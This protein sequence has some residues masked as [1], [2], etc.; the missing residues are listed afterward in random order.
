MTNLFADLPH[1]LPD[2]LFTTPL[3][4]TNVRIERIVSQGHSSPAGFWYEEDQHEMVIVLKGGGLARFRGSN[5]RDKARRLP[6]HPGPREA[7]C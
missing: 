3:E 2:E 7:P 5:R 4:T 1:H 6:E